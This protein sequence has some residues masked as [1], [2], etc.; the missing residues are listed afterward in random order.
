[1]SDT[2]ERMIDA[3]ISR[4]DIDLAKRFGFFMYFWQSE[5][6]HWGRWHVLV[7]D[8]NI[9]AIEPHMPKRG[10]TMSDM[11]VAFYNIIQDTS[12][13]DQARAQLIDAAAK[14]VHGD[15][16][17]R[18]AESDGEWVGVKS[19]AHELPDM[20]VNTATGKMR[21]VGPDQVRPAG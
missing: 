7:E 19:L 1:M 9:G 16:W 5:H 3:A 6:G 8:G 18:G 17:V 13:A 20:Q 15:W 2:L 21:W 14:G 4:C 11:E 12:E 10:Q